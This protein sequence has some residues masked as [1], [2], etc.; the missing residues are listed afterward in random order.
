MPCRDLFAY[1]REFRNAGFTRI[2][3]IDEVGR[4]PLAGPVVAAAVVLP[5]D[6][7]AEGLR[8]SKQV[9]PD[10]R[11]DIYLRI[12]DGCIDFGVG[13]VDADVIDRVN[14]LQATKM[15][16]RIALDALKTPPDLLLI[17]ALRL[18]GVD[19]EQRGIV[20]GDDTSASI[21]AASI[22]AKEVRD[23]MMRS[24]HN[25]FPQ[26]GFNGHKGYGTKL[27]LERIEQHGPCAIHR[28]TFGGVSQRR[29]F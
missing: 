19:I 7:F 10:S 8:D 22:V 27:H 2:A 3:G 28:M 18:D 26:Y 21:A 24:Y 20:K 16:M 9:K 15:A 1:D 6:F 11:Y 12:L 5:G 4:G 23:S 13:V 29:L 17:D 25:Q 14:I